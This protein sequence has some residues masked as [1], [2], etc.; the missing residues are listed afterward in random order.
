MC[1]ITEVQRRLGAR[2]RTRRAQLGL[3]QLV[4]A[5]RSGF[6]RPSIANV[7]AGRQNVTLRQLCAV[8]GALEVDVSELVRAGTPGSEGAGA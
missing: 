4:L 8:A 6:S 3:T 7:E 2:I 1:D 5:T